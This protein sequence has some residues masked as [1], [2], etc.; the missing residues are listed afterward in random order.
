MKIGII[1]KVIWEENSLKII[2]KILKVEGGMYLN[3]ISG[4]VKGM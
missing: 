3:G 2:N 4:D 1:W